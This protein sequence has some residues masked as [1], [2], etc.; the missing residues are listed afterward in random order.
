MSFSWSYDCSSNGYAWS[1][2]TVAEKG[3]LLPFVKIA[4][5]NGNRSPQ[6]K[7]KLVMEEY[8]YARICLDA[9]IEIEGVVRRIVYS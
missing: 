9:T 7:S 6:W 2:S 8:S 5:R 1:Y 3:H 4:I